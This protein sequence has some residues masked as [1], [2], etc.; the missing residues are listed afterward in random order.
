MLRFTAVALGLVTGAHGLVITMGFIFGVIHI[1]TYW[2]RSLI[3]LPITL[4]LYSYIPIMMAHT[5]RAD[6]T[7]LLSSNW[8]D[9]VIY[10]KLGSSSY[11]WGNM[12]I[13]GLPARLLDTILILT[14]SIGLVVIGLF[15]FIKKN[16]SFDEHIKKKLRTFKR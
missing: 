9:Y 2:K 7:T 3:I 13:Q 14:G 15:Y 8:R 1:R 16:I 4:L 10:F 6:A 5:E 11:W 12:P